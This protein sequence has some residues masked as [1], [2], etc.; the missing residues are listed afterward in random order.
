MSAFDYDLFVIGG[1]SGGVRAARLAAQLG[2]KVGLA[3]ESR[4]GGTCVVRGCVPKKLMVYASQFSSDFQDANGY[5]WTIENT[6]FDWEK[7][8]QAKEKEITRLSGIYESNLKKAGADI[9]LERAE[10][11]SDHEVLLKDTGKVISA[12][13]ILIAVGGKPFKPQLKGI[14]HAITSNEIFDLPRFPKSLAIVGGGY[15]ASEFACI[16]AGLGSEVTQIYR[17]NQILRGFD[18]DLRNGVAHEMQNKG[19]SFRLN[20]D[21]KNITSKNNALNIVLKDKTSI[22]VDQ[23]LYATGREPLTRHLQL[24]K[25]GIEMDKD[26]AVIVDAFSKTNQ[27]HIF[28]V[29]DVTNRVNLTPVAIREAAAFID[30]V[31]NN[32]PISVDH[33]DIPTAVFTQPEI[34]TVGLSETQAVEKYKKVDIYRSEFRPMRNILAGRDEKMMMKL[35]V[36]AEDQRVRGI[37]I[38]GHAAGEMIQLAGIAVKMKA[39]KADFDATMAVHPTAAEELVTMKEPYQRYV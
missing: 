14:E 13:N 7:L 37:H 15:I 11:K 18:D 38:Y 16:F 12:K 20:N 39:T 34:G 21:V 35:V 24:G 4:M 10:F 1:G 25:V 19:I 23:I 33:Q 30:T 32:K 17:S 2:Y 6:S 9:F 26:G 8:V 5:G 29:G 27:P 3:E 31:F 36:S 22:D 28:A